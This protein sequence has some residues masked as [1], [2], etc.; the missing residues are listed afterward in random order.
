MASMSWAKVWIMSGS[1]IGDIK[2]ENRPI[3]TGL[4][5]AGWKNDPK[6]EP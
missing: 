6:I 3:F 2:V 1:A 4:Y 5:L